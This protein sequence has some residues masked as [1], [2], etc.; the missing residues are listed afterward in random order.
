MTIL[1]T[2]FISRMDSLSVF[3]ALGLTFIASLS[4]YVLVREKLSSIT[5]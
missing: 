5:L 3:L 2:I 4:G 1:D